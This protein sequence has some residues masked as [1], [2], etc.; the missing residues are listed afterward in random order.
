MYRMG[1]L[2]PAYRLPMV[3]PGPANQKKIERV[4][5]EVGLAVP[6]GGAAVATGD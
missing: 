3:P 1:L 2:E 4:L 5:E 6:A